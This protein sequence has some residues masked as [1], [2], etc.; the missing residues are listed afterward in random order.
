VLLLR[1]CCCLLLYE[2]K[3]EFVEYMDQQA[4]QGGHGAISTYHQKEAA[5]R[6]AHNELKK[7]EIADVF[8]H[9]DRVPPVNVTLPG[10]ILAYKQLP[11]ELIPTCPQKKCGGTKTF[12]KWA[13]EADKKT[14]ARVEIQLNNRC[15]YIRATAG[16]H[17]WDAAAW[18]SPLRAWGSLPQWKNSPVLA[19]ADVSKEVQ[20]D[21]GCWG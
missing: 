16:G 18:G 7:K 11:E 14:S 1:F 19:W 3:P 21:S 4:M 20:W 6:K 2:A 8:V 12:T 5:S 15:F 10:C 9:E 17:L 13:K